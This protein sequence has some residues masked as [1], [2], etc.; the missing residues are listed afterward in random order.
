LAVGW[1]GRLPDTKH[2]K[3]SYPIFVHGNVDPKTPLVQYY[4]VILLVKKKIS[5][6]SYGFVAMG[7]PETIPFFG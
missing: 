1:D 5:N 2:K 3:R 4:N 7:R 6:F